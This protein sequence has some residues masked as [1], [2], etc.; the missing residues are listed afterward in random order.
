MSARE[1][2]LRRVVPGASPELIA[3]LAAR[4]LGEVDLIVALARQA[5]RDALSDDKAKRRQRKRDDREYGN[6]DEADLAA[7]NLRLISRQGIRAASNLDA[8]AGMAE[9]RTV[10]GDRIAAAVSGLRDHGYSDAEIGRALAVDRETVG[11]WFGRRQDRIQRQE[12]VT[13]PDGIRGVA[14]GP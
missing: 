12:I 2:R 8:L 1:Q 5:R 10:L 13:P 14:D 6:Y 11:R 7:R 9:A 4:P 3:A